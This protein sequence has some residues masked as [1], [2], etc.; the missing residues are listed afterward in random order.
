M[1]L[2]FFCSAFRCF[3]ASSAGGSEG[4][5]SLCRAHGRRRRGGRRRGRRVAAVVAATVAGVQSEGG[6][7]RRQQREE[8]RRREPHCRWGGVRA[9]GLRVLCALMMAAVA[10]TLDPELDSAAAA[11]GGGGRTTRRWR[12]A[13][14]MS[15]FQVPLS[16]RRR[17]VAVE[18][19]EDRTA[20]M[21]SHEELA[22]VG[23]LHDGHACRLLVVL[24]GDDPCA[25][26]H[27]KSKCACTMGT[28][29]QND[30]Y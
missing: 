14:H 11:R 16:R 22:R 8:W 21:R 15:Q 27:Y 2:G 17:V 12:P 13:P 25:R 19:C 20:H 10:A 3:L 24:K 5:R 9:R 28:P 6:Q 7:G 4:V 1:T 23:V 18:P 26:R 30:S 29:Q